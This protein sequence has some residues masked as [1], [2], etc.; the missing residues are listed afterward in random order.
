M[1]PWTVTPDGIAIAVRLTPK[2]DRDAVEGIEPLADG[3]CALKVRVR[4][5]ASEGQANDA[6]IRLLA[7]TLGI[8]P[9][10]VALVAGATARLKRLTVA[11]NG[12]RLAAA[13]ETI[14]GEGRSR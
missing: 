14:I 4:A 13:L 6:L 3:R 8:A 12:P 7:R 10:A 9:R 1:R 2:G 11:G 5:P